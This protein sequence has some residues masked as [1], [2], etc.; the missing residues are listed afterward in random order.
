MPLPHQGQLVERNNMK[1]TYIDMK[2]NMIV[3]GKFTDIYSFVK[4]ILFLM[5]LMTVG[6][7][8]VW[9]QSESAT[10]PDGDGYYY[11]INM[12]AANNGH[13]YDKDK[14]D[15]WYLCPIEGDY[16]YL[17]WQNDREMPFITTNKEGRLAKYLWRVVKNGDYYYIIHDIDNKYL[18]AND[19]PGGDDK[20]TRRRVHIQEEVT[21]KASFKLKASG[22]TSYGTDTYN[23]SSPSY[24]D[25]NLLNPAGNNNANYGQDKNRAGLIG[26]F[27]DNAGSRWFFEF[28]KKCVTPEITVVGGN[29]TITT[30]TPEATIYYTDDNS[31]PATSGTRQEYSAPFSLG[32]ATK[33]KAIAIKADLEN[34]DEAV[35]NSTKCQVPTITL[36][37]SD[38]STTITPNAADEGAH[39]YYTIDGTTPTTH[40]TEYTGPFTL[41]VDATVLK[42]IAA[43]AADGSDR[44]DVAEQTLT[45][46]A[47]PT[48]SKSDATVTITKP[49]KESDE[50]TDLV[51]PDAV[52]VRYNL[53][54]NNPTSSSTL[55]ENAITLSVDFNQTIIKAI[56][57]KAGYVKSDVA[58]LSIDRCATPT[59]TN[60]GDGTVTFSCATDEATIRYTYSTTLTAPSDPKPTSTVAIGTF[61]LPEGTKIVKARAFKA[62]FA[63]SSVLTYTLPKFSMPKI[64]FHEG[65]ITITCKSGGTIYY[66][67]SE[68]GTPSTPYPEGGFSLGSATVVRAYATHI[69]YL[70]SDIRTWMTPKATISSMVASLV[71]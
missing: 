42:A 13:T 8:E 25:G 31:D 22:T 36:D 2:R 59:V 19:Y 17:H 54:N 7:S 28:V 21:T 15:N 10:L 32:S 71:L 47:P 55:Y 35:Y 70:D 61:D 20:N 65:T 12:E 1:T 5:A 44:S 40:S 51:G 41:S 6:V 64:T 43:F 50:T 27:S 63:Q 52:E 45:K 23:I 3:N 33:I 34:S 66:T 24:G 69:G 11:I 57:Y 53:N 18:T 48:W 38:G 30:V 49:T 58:S 9:G 39:I 16:D 56:A 4:N 14:A 60:H 37:K 68:S 29:V 62:G 67:T 46:L 26:F